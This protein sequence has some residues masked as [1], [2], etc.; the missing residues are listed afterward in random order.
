MAVEKILVVDDEEII[1][2]T[3][4]KLLLGVGYEVDTAEN[5]IAAVEM[6]SKRYE[7]IITDLVM[8]GLDGIGVLEKAKEE[9]SHQEVF[10]LT[11]QGKL[12]SAIHA[13]RLGASDY[14]LKPYN[15]EELILRIKNCL[16]KKRLQEKINFYEDI[17]PICCDCGKIRDDEVS[18]DESRKWFSVEE[19]ITRKMNLKPSH[20]YC[21]EC[22][23]KQLDRI[24]K[25]KKRY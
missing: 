5:G 10:I 25:M 3:L 11:G 4:Q 12:D 19:Y 7:L 20:G 13:L 17:L 23:Q 16:E 1:R 18:G 22:G 2:F 24:S 8:D 21:D 15:P 14:L 9:D 6:L